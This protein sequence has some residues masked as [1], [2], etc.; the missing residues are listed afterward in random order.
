MHR[1]IAVLIITLF[2][3]PCT[4]AQFGKKLK[5]LGEKVQKKIDD[6]F[7]Q[8]E[9]GGGGEFEKLRKKQLQKDTTYYNYGLAQAEKISLFNS[10]DDNQGVLLLAAKNYES[11]FVEKPELLPYEQAFDYNRAGS[12]ALTINKRLARF[13]FLQAMAIYLN[14]ESISQYVFSGYDDDELDRV[15]PALV[16]DNLDRPDQYAVAKTF[17]NLATFYH[18]RGQYKD[19][20]N[21]NRAL[22]F[23][24]KDKLGKNSLALAATLN[25]LGL[26]ERDLGNYAEAEE[27]LEGARAILSGSGNEAKLD[28][29]VLLN[30]EAMLYQEIGQYKKAIEKIDQALTLAGDKLSNKGTD[31]S[32]LRLNKALIFKAQKEYDKA[33]FILL[34]L[35]QTKERRFGKRHQDY[36]DIESILAALYMEKGETGK[37][38]DL[39]KD[40][41][42]IYENKFS[43][44]HPAYTSTLRSLAQY[45]YLTDQYDQAL[46]TSDQVLELV[47][48]GFGDQHPDYL[49][50]IEDM[51]LIHWNSGNLNDAVDRF[52]EANQLKLDLL[53]KFFPALSE[54]EKS[55]L[56]A[57]MRPS[58]EK[59]FAFVS[60][61][62]NPTQSLLEEMYDIQLA[63]KGILLSSTTKVRQEILSSDNEELKKQYTQ[64]ISLKEELANYYTLS[65][66]EISE[67]QINLDSVE[68]A[69]N[70]LEKE[71]SKSSS[72]FASANQLTNTKS[73][74]LKSLLADNEAAIEIIRIRD[75]KKTFQENIIYIALV[76]DKGQGINLVKFDNGVDMEGKLASIYRKSIQ[77]KVADNRSYQNF[78]GP[79]SE[80]TNSKSTLYLSLDGVFNQISLNTLKDGNG[81]YLGDQQLLVTVSSTRD[82]KNINRNSSP[83]DNVLMFGFPNYGGT[84]AVA[85]LPGTKVELDKIGQ[86]LKSKGLSTQQYLQ[87]EANEALFK[88]E[89]KNPEVLHIATHGFFLDAVNDKED[90][91]FGVEISK[92]QE[93][94]LL[95]SGLMLA[96]AE[97]TIKNIDSK[98][99]NSANNGILT[100]YEAMT[101][102][103]AKTKMVVLSACETGL[104]EIK[105]GEGVYG[106]QRAFQIAGAETIVM[107]LWKVNDDATQKLMTT[108]YSNWLSSGDKLLAFQNA[109]KSLR[110]EYEEPYYWGAFVMM[111]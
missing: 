76:L 101:L 18:T 34:S 14:T 6:P 60:S 81:K 93:N 104:G 66:A 7:G 84:G 107:S 30:N 89:V 75:F 20:E 3:V 56:W 27:H 106:L 109:Q 88:K 77:F 11:E 99:V 13:N 61:Y 79:I 72:A 43:R 38:E 86:I 96:D 50:I 24:I 33:E 110:E 41:L 102:D 52:K 85:E 49:Q 32:K 37:V 87:K 74:D 12:N 9:N 4:Q 108:F 46:N 54:N 26:I 82:I 57:K 68:N 35:K 45:Y 31:Y 92:A 25:N 100:A 36:A 59:F 98:Q 23:Y 21:L 22:T 51:A 111:N 62:E 19:A 64:W 15:I 10:R 63:T 71:L 29:A 28:M 39:L 5:S 91:V 67:Q 69:A 8:D 42:D 73:N 70:Q 48:S 55:K 40:A 53:E 90:V 80:L 83:M 65:K 78:W 17:M 2:I 1:L 103:L 105:S 95:R 97:K 47:I 58:F 94:P 16:S 44:E